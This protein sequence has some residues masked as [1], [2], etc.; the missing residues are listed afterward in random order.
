MSNPRLD[1]LAKVPVTH[2]TKVQ[3]GEVVL[4]EVIDVPDEVPIAIVRAVREAG[5]IPLVDIKQNRVQ[6][7]LIRCGNEDG[8]RLIGEYEAFRMK[9]VQAYIG[10][11]GG[12]NIAEMSDVPPEAMRLYQN[13]L[14]EACTSGYPSP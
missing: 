8:L 13:A 7:E 11:R 12:Y 2:S 14:D 5:G 4:I 10:I 3:P 9:K 1:Q 6:R